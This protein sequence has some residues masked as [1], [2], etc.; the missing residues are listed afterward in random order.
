LIGSE[1]ARRERELAQL[2]LGIPGQTSAERALQ[3]IDEEIQRLYNLEVR[4]LEKYPSI[5]P[6]FIF[7][8]LDASSTDGSQRTPVLYIRPD[9]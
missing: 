9:R 2:V 5:A 1:L 6:P 8:V 7:R 3:M 4:L